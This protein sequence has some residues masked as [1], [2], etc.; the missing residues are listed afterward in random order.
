MRIGMLTGMFYKE[1]FRLKKNLYAKAI[2]VSMMAFLHYYVKAQSPGGWEIV[3]LNYHLSKKASVFFEAQVKSQELMNDFYYNEYKIYGLY[4]LTNK[5]NLTAGA[6]NFKTYSSPGNF[7][8]PLEKSE[9]R[10]WQQVA[11]RSRSGRFNFQNR[12]RT[13]QRWINHIYQNR[14]SYRLN[15]VVPIN[16]KKLDPKTFY[17]SVYDEIYFTNRHPYYEMDRW[18][19]GLGFQVSSFFALQT[20]FIKQYN[21]HST[22]I[23]F[24]QSSFLFSL[25]DK[26]I[27][28]NIQSILH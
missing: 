16:H 2:I 20:G 17:A 7:K 10:T 25:N 9:F 5:W 21:Y 12:L 4:N 19:I 23:Q 3:N 11:L 22:S 28:K 13:E 14:F 18:F 24:I 8:S 6:G 15:S 26:G 27:R 1:N